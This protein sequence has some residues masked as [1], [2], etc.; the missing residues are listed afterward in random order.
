MHIHKFYILQSPREKAEVSTVKPPNATYFSQNF[1]IRV[2]VHI[3]NI[4]VCILYMSIYSADDI[5]IYTY[6][7]KRESRGTV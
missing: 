3:H 7:K 5:Y 2:H 4:Y 1:S 6:A